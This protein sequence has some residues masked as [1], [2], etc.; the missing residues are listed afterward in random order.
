MAFGVIYFGQDRED[1][2][3]FGL[4]RRLLEI[5]IDGL[6]DLVPI[7]QNPLAHPDQFLDPLRGFCVSH[8]LQEMC[9]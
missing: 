2:T 9:L 4:C 6:G 3:Q 7:G 8:L 5:C 1:F